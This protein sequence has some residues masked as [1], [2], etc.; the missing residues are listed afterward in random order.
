MVYLPALEGNKQREV[1][2][3]FSLDPWWRSVTPPCPSR[4][5]PVRGA[6]LLNPWLLTF[7]VFFYIQVG[8][9]V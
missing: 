7:L 2:K 6:G 1:G 4:W 8:F 3:R 9:L 5:G